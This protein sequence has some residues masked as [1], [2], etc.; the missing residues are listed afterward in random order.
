[1]LTKIL[2]VLLLIFGIITM[3]IFKNSILIT[4]ITILLVSTAYLQGLIDD[5]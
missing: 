5:M 3:C 4:I 1:M 2:E